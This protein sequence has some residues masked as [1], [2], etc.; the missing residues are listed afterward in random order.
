MYTVIGHPNSRAGRVTWAL[1]EMGLEWTLTPA[2]PQSDEIRAVNPGGKIPALRVDDTVIIDSVAIITFL[3]DR[4]GALTAPAG[5]TARGQQDSFTQFA[6]DEMDASLWTAAKSRFALPEEQRV[7]AIKDTAIWEWQRACRTLETRL[8]DRTFVMGDE[9]TLPDIVIGHC[10]GWANAAKFGWPDG[11]VGA[12]FDRLTSR[13][14]R[15]RAFKKALSFVP[16]D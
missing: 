13:P 11:P 3:A 10:A 2:A 1:E 9:L 16:A 4:H 15:K 6:C 8:G 12:Y 5:T 14:A 7:P